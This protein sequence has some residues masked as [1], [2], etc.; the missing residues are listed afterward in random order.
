MRGPTSSRWRRLAAALALT[1]AI[2]VVAAAGASG[3]EYNREYEHALS[4]GTQAYVY[5]EPLLD[6]QRVFQSMTSVTVPDDVGDAPVNQFSHFTELANTKEG[7]VV[8]P[9]AD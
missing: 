8:D 1:C 7:L 3:E 5:A 4:V 9:N 6:M 2:S